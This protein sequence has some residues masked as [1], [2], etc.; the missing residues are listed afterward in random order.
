MTKTTF[1]I[2]FAGWIVVLGGLIS[3]SPIIGLSLALFVSLTIF[4]LHLRWISNRGAKQPT[5][6]NQ[7]G[8]K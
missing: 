4:N 1:K 7:G 2:I 3:L 5:T 8:P 6:N